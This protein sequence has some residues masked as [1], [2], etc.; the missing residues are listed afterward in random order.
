MT[1]LESFD[2]VTKKYLSFDDRKTKL[3]DKKERILF[4]KHFF[5]IVK[6]SLFGKIFFWCSSYHQVLL[7]FKY[8]ILYPLFLFSIY[9][10]A[11]KTGNLLQI[12]GMMVCS[13][14]FCAVGFSWLHM[15]IH[16]VTLDYHWSGVNRLYSSFGYWHHFRTRDTFLS[17]IFI[18]FFGT[19]S[20]KYILVPILYQLLQTILGIYT[21]MYDNYAQLIFSYWFFWWVLQAGSHAYAHNEKLPIG[22]KYLMISLSKLNLLPSHEK[23]KLHHNY[24]GKT[25]YQYF[26]D[27]NTP[28]LD[29]ITNYYWNYMF[30]RYFHLGK[31]TTIMRPNSYFTSLITWTFCYV[32]LLFTGYILRLPQIN[33]SLL[34]WYFLFFGAVP[35]FWRSIGKCLN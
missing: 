5:E 18:T 4:E 1:N 24:S 26:S 8:S 12:F 13:F 20:R 28:T 29:K 23:H 10:M 35:S 22:F 32:H 14:Y 16:A 2:P 30:K 17:Q 3:F 7:Y 34:L 27:L 21:I 9:N 11:F 33:K 6:N 25:K 15:S 19:S 31:M